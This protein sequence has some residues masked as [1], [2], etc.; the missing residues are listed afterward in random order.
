MHSRRAAAALELLIALG[1]LVFSISASISLVFGNQSVS[2][3]TD[4]NSE[5]LLLAEKNLEDARANSRAVFNSVFS[6]DI[7]ALNPLFTSALHV[8]DISQCKKEVS[9]VVSWNVSPLRPRQVSLSTAL[10][11]VTS[12]IVLDGDCSDEGPGGP[13]DSPGSYDFSDPVHPGSAG[14]DIDVIKRTDGRFVLLTTDKVGTKETL[15]MID[16]SDPQ[17]IAPSLTD[18]YDTEADL[19]AVDATKDHAFATGASADQLQIINIANPA[20]LLL[21]ATTSLPDADSG[22]GRSIYYYD[23]K[24]Y[25]GTQY[26]PCPSCASGQNNELHIFDVSDPAS[27]SWKASINVDRN[28]NDIMVRDGLAYLAIGPGGTNDIFRIYD[29]DSSSATYLDE[30]GSFTVPGGEQGTSLYLL[31]NKVYLGRERTPSARNDFYILDVSSPTSTTERWSGRLALN[32][33]AEVVGIFVSGNLAFLS[34]N[35]TTPDNGGGPFMV[36]DIS[37]PANPSLIIPCSSF[38]YSEKTTGMDF[39]EGLIFTSNESQD[40]IRI[41]YPEPSCS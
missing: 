33:G 13:W 16:V 41:I 10:V 35:D 5:A 19:F 39:M 9:S 38:N 12:A 37:D 21:T 30:V 29:V 15:W 22:I 20:D 24:I 4:T 26:L 32:P 3:D 11:D 36:Y 28:V 2:V 25:V 17:N 1:V 14:T 18:A 40:S 34:T 27:P 7:A 23:N 6:M 31:G 8:L